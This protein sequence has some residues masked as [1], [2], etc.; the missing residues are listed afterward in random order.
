MDEEE[1]LSQLDTIIERFTKSA[2]VT[3]LNQAIGMYEQIWSHIQNEFP[4]RKDLDLLKVKKIS[5]SDGIFL[6]PEERKTRREKLQNNARVLKKILET[7]YTKKSDMTKIGD[8]LTN[9]GL[10]HYD[11]FLSHSDRQKV[12]AGDIKRGLEDII[13]CD[14][15]L[16]HDDL[17]GGEIWQDGLRTRIKN[18]EYFLIL[19]SR[20]YHESNYT[21]QETGI[22]YAYD[23]HIIPIS[24]DGTIPYGFMHIYQPIKATDLKKTVI[25]EIAKQI[26]N[27]G[28]S[29]NERINHYIQL[30]KNSYSFNNAIF[31][32]G[33]L[34]YQHEYSKEQINKLADIFIENDQVNGSVK[35]GPHIEFILN[36]NKSLIENRFHDK[37]PKNILED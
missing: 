36:K 11:I 9:K 24:I 4:E 13:N 10:K 1:I 23:K 29:T 20:E 35:A 34:P 21:D 25:Y 7:N 15:F 19:L 33:L 5:A 26:I 3:E 27:K 30:L 32:S 31:L 16:A 2:T 6:G 14:V 22:A 28:I 8:T 17:E 37:L 12:L 18:C